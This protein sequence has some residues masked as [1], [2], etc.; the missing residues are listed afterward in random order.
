MTLLV[1][2]FVN[3][4]PPLNYVRLKILRRIQDGGT[5]PLLCPG[6]WNKQAGPGG[7]RD[8]G[9]RRGRDNL[10]KPVSRYLPLTQ[11][12][13]VDAVQPRSG[14]CQASDNQPGGARA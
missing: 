7:P 6:A 8:T 10:P 11:R 2:L 5:V 1:S 13:G 9:G 12:Y 14:R 4:H 3:Y